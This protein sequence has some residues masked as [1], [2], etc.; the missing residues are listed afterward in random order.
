MKIVLR[1]LNLIIGATVILVA[2]ALYK[3]RSAII[4][5]KVNQNIV[6]E[7]V[8]TTFDYPNPYRLNFVAQYRFVEQVGEFLVRRDNFQNIIGGLAE[9]WT[10]SK[11]RHSIIFHLRPN[12]YSAEEVAQSL[13][14]LIKAKQTSHS[15]LAHQI[16]SAEDIEVIDSS[17]LM[18]KTT[19]DAGAILA[20]LVMSDTV[21][22]PDDHWINVPGFDEPQVD[23]T[24]T[25]G[26]Y[27]HESGSFLS[28]ANEG[29]IYKPNPNH[30]FFFARPVE[31][32][33]HL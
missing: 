14:R 19:S 13:R 16:S 30:Y 31:M 5:D 29:L 2:I 23:W 25:K 26:P 24:K 21:I 8:T 32:E 4:G 9:S 18:I 28:L 11:D 7:L 1:P 3:Y 12:I 10:I 6:T 15:N 22:L 17:N 20:P 27:I 33:N